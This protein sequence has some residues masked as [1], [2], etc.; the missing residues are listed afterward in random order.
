MLLPPYLPYLWRPNPD[1]HTCPRDHYN[2]PKYLYSCPKYPYTC[3]RDHYNCEKH[4]VD[5]DANASFNDT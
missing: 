4:S 5:P 1:H 2:H 3:P